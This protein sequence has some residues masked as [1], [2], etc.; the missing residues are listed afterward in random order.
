MAKRYL[1]DTCA[2][3]KYLTIVFPPNGISFMDYIVDEES[4]ISFISE[5]ELQVWNPPDPSDIEIYK[6]FISGSNIITI[7]D[8]IIKKTIDIR[9]NH[10]LKIP[11]AI[12]AATAMVNNLILVS[13]NDKD[14]LKVPGLKYKNP[15]SMV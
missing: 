13:D 9:K 2:V 14:F 3:I 12:I 1:I 6:D 5:I 7:E 10:K 4:V 15:A 11:D 8:S